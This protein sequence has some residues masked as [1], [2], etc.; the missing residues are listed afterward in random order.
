LQKEKPVKGRREMLNIQ[1]MSEPE[2]LQEYIR[3]Q[4]PKNWDDFTPQI[5]QKIKETILENEQKIHEDCVCV[6]CERIVDS[7]GSHIEHIKPKD[8]YPQSFKAFDNL[9]VSCNSPVTCGHKKGNFYDAKFIHPVEDNPHLFMT[10]EISTEKIIPQN[11]SFEDRVN[12]TCE[13]LN[14]NKNA[15]L[16]N[17]RKTVLLQLI[18]SG[19][20]AIDWIDYFN[21]FNSL[22]YYYK[23]EILSV[24]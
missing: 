3:I 13:I 16:L 21:E 1:K 12:Y 23:E 9:T 24:I 10:Y 20:N 7:G 5:K 8:K 6:Y 18:A 11:N 4:K 22:I 19:K 14:F 17:A 15:E 2:Y